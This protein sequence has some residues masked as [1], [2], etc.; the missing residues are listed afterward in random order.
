[1]RYKVTIKKKKSYKNI[2]IVTNKIG[3]KNYKNIS[4]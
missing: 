3:K 2:Y 4:A 1:M